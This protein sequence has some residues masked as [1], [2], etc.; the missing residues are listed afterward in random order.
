MVYR[1]TSG[2]GGAPITTNSPIY[3]YSTGNGGSAPPTLDRAKFQTNKVNRVLPAPTGEGLGLLNKDMAK[4]G[5]APSG[6]Q[7]PFGPGKH[8]AAG[9]SVPPIGQRGAKLSPQTA[10]GIPIRDD[11]NRRASA[12]ELYSRSAG[13]RPTGK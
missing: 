9:V 3:D 11:F 6:S 1:H 2:G 7:M 4:A 5:T 8:E 10:R 13:R 12:H